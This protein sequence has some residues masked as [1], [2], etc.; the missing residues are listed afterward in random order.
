MVGRVLDRMME[1]DHFPEGDRRAFHRYRIR[2]RQTR[3]K[4]R[5]ESNAR[6][7]LFK[8]IADSH[9][10]LDLM[11][12]HPPSRALWVYRRWPDVVNSAVKA[13]GG[14]WL[15]VMQGIAGGTGDWGWRQERISD[16]C[17]RTVRELVRPDMTPWDAMA[18]FWFLR[19][20]IYFDQGLD[21]RRDVMLVRY[22]A[23][24]TDPPT[25]FERICAFLGIEFQPEAVASVHARSIRKAPCPVTNQDITGTCDALLSE[26]DETWERLR[27]EQ[28]QR[29]VEH[30]PTSPGTDASAH[31]R[32]G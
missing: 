13:W 25:A 1:V 4:L 8:P 22:E 32:R 12:D 31:D 17:L 21:H 19:N 23:L 11:A 30:A 24:V 15:E 26:M 9:L 20:R 2:D 10:V 16:D 3:D 29:V 27:I 7:V 5:A 28:W 14:H 6:C 18:I